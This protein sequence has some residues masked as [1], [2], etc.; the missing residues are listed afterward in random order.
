MRGGKNLRSRAQ[1]LIDGDLMVDFG[2][3]TLMHAL[4]DGL[5]LSALTT[6]LVTHAHSDHFYPEELAMHRPVY[7]HGASH[8]DV[9]G[10]EN[11]VENL[12]N[13]STLKNINMDIHLA[14][15]FERFNVGQ[16][17]VLP[18]RA[19]HDRRQNCLMFVIERGGKRLFYAH[20]TGYY[21]EETWEAI[22]GM[23][24]D[25]VICECTTGKDKDGRNHLG[26]AD[27]FEV[28]ERLAKEGC[29]MGDT[30]FVITHFSHNGGLLHEELEEVFSRDG[31]VVA[32]DG[33]EINI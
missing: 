8:L 5:D 25:C 17:S 16:T 24:M 29:V 12:E 2:P 1:S 20:D 6:L 11:V 3:D 31:M 13:V 32:Y 30:R 19:L 14:V 33:I 23:H 27:V 22:R 26:V 28:H 18:L 4:R 7:G 21:P 9:F 10:N 15:A